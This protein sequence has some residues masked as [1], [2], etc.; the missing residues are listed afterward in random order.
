MFPS[1][2]QFQRADI[3]KNGMKCFFKKKNP[4]IGCWWFMSV[5]SIFKFIF[6]VGGC[7]CMWIH[8]VNTGKKIEL[9]VMEAEQQRT[10]SNYKYNMGRTNFDLKFIPSTI[11]CLCLSVNI[12]LIK[13]PLSLYTNDLFRKC[14][15]IFGD[16]DDATTIA[17]A[18]ADDN[19]EN[20]N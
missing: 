15:C 17:A 5:C 13:K 8:F 11:L 9:L 19:V 7:I 20:N 3:C 18:A 12:D 16:N 4:K 10:G 14:F 1:S 6:H 2:Y